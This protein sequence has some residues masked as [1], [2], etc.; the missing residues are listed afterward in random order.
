MS[1]SYI[2]R[3]GRGRLL[4][5][6][7][8]ALKARRPQPRQLITLILHLMSYECI[9][10]YIYRHTSALALVV[11]TSVGRYE[12][13]KEKLQREFSQTGVSLYKKCIIYKNTHVK[14]SEIN[15]NSRG[16]RLCNQKQDIKC[17]L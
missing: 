3:Q 17:T 4:I 5:L 2:A 11:I 13:G 9:V 10:I 16:D 1:T 8:K 6:T 14:D 12:I 7:R 15:A